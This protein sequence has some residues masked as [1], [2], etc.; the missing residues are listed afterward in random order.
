MEFEKHNLYKG[1]LFLKEGKSAYGIYKK[2]NDIL[3]RTATEI[4]S[5]ITDSLR[6]IMMVKFI[7]YMIFVIETIV[8]SITLA[9]GSS[10]LLSVFL[11]IAA[12]AILYKLLN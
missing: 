12:I 1:H 9:I 10:G 2:T 8:L 4:A 3:A 5:L 11:E 6:I 7:F